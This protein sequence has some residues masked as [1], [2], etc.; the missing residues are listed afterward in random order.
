MYTS[1]NPVKH[2]TFQRSPDNSRVSRWVAKSSD[3]K[4]INKDNYETIIRVDGK[5]FTKVEFQ[6]TPT[7]IP[8]PK[9]YAP[10]SP[11][12]DGGMLFH[13]GRFFTCPELCDNSLNTWHISV[14]ASKEESIIV[15]GVVHSGVVSWIDSGEGKKVYVGKN[16]PIQDEHFVSLIDENLPILLKQLMSQ[17]LPKLL[18]FFP[19]NMGALSYRPSLYASY[20]Q[21]DDGRYGNQGGTLPGQIFMHWYGD[22]SIEKLNEEATLWFFA[23]EVAHLYQG[24]GVDINALSDAWVHEGSAEL[25]AGIAYTKISGD[26]NLF[27]KKLD[28]AKQTCLNILENEK[29]YKKAALTNP[30]VHYSCG[31]LLFYALNTDLKEHNNSIF[32]L[33][34]SFDTSVKQGNSASSSTFIEIAKPY[35]SH[36]LWSKLSNFVLMPEFNSKAFFQNIATNKSI[37]PTANAAA[38]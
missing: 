11:F 1:D 35:I 21:S 13:S 18:S 15:D 5:P 22:K 25:F 34:D 27:I 37:Q 30:K 28:D 16:K 9:E 19:E 38:D 12:S 10:F 3:F 29:N 7:Y 14:Q 23:H 32:E 8:L 26:T 31:L 2:I 24:R 17:Y 20:S 33:W 4:I 6:L 36:G